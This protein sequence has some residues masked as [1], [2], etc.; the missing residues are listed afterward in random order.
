VHVVGP[1]GIQFDEAYIEVRRPA[2]VFIPSPRLK[3]RPV[4][5]GFLGFRWED[6]GGYSGISAS[7]LV[8]RLRTLSVPYWA[9]AALAAA[10]RLVLLAR[11]SRRARRVRDGV[12]P[13]CGY[14]LR[15]TPGR[16]PECGTAASVSTTDEAPVAQPLP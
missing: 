11:D 7:K 4:S 1:N 8:V 3:F 13:S 10:P 14:D 5:V 9:L 2:P 15:A 16:C 12:C 6:A